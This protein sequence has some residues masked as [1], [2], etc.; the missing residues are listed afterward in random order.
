MRLPLVIVIALGCISCASAFAA[1]SQPVSTI[2]T[3]KPSPEK[4]F[5]WPYYLYIPPASEVKVANEEVVHLIVSTNNTG[6][7]SDRFLHHEC[8][9]LRLLSRLARNGYKFGC[10]CLVPVFP[11]P[12]EYD[13]IYTHALDRD[14]LTTELEGLKRLDLQLLA[15]IDD[16]RERLGQEGLQVSEKILLTGFSAS[17]SFANRFTVLH[18]ERVLAAV[19]GSPGG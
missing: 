10:P 17:G 8:S 15:M 4:G 11:R 14:C 1:D 2:L 13:S 5:E 7:T 3:V 6:Q 18:P 12:K 9:A 16:A 19:I